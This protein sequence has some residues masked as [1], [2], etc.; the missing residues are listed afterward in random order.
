VHGRRAVVSYVV[1][2]GYRGRYVVNHSFRVERW[3]H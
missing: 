1:C 2:D 3:L